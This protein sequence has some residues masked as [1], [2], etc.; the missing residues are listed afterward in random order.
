MLNTTMNFSTGATAFSF[1]NQRPR[2][3][4]LDNVVCT[5]NETSLHECQNAGI[6]VHNCSH[7]EYAGVRCQRK[8]VCL[9]ELY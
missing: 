7:D 6:G 3:I 5:G 4:W 9:F 1:F 2:S 8:Q